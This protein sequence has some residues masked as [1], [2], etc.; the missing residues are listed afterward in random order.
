MKIGYV[1]AGS[2]PTEFL[3]TL[4]PERPVRLYEYVAVDSVEIPPDGEEAAQVRLI[5]QIVKIIRDPYQLKRDI[6]LYNVVEGVSHD[7][8]E[9]Q[10]A[11]VK[12]LGYL[13][14][15]EIHMPKLPPRI[16]A[17][18]YLAKDDEVAELYGSGELCVGR[19]SARPLDLCLDV[20][21]LKRHMAVIAATGSGKTWF[22]VV[23]IEELLKRGASVVVLDPHGEYVAARDTAQRLGGVNALTVKVS[24][25][26][27]GDVMYRIGVL[28]MDP[29]ALADAAGVPPKAT[30][31][32]YSIYLA[33]ALAKSAYKAGARRMGPKGL[34]SILSAALRG[35]QHLKRLL[36]QWGVE[37]EKADELAELAKRDRHSI[38]SAAAYLRRLARLGVFSARTTPLG[39]ITADLTVVNLAG[40]GD[41]IQDYVAWH[42]LTRIFKARVRHVRGLPG[43][44]LERPVVV[45]LEE[46]HR[47]APPKSARRTRAYEAVSRIAAEGRKF[48]VYL[49]VVTQRPSRVDPDVMSQMQSQ[50]IMRIVNPK[51]QEAVRDSSEQLAQD[52][53]DNLPGLDRGEAVVL[54]PVVKL[55]AVIR[56]RDR[57]LDYGGADIS[58]AE[59]WRRSDAD[60]ATIWA[61]IFRSPPPP[62]VVLAASGISVKSAEPDGGVWR[63]VTSDGARVELSIESGYAR[64]SV[65]GS[66]GCAH[67]YRVLSEIVKVR[68]AA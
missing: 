37:D 11:K 46:A 22:S 31:I 60:V 26:H 44:K 7:L 5:G 2:T 38:F 10:I 16:G 34:A 68:R 39:R 63:A 8:L 42:I 6:P 29:D 43:V 12:I 59:A 56:L 13:W 50:V 19:L 23:L 32:R 21:G 30:K 55:P 57:V 61:R 52:Y 28:D 51:D 27:A 35:E 33:H 54:G 53:L 45:V 66:S 41:E 15:G 40:V 58:L 18:V 47:F 64:C 3:A 67:V 17:P 25:H 62:S 49:V 20:E 9:V 36:R 24:G 4:D 48:G 1:I 65:C 14:N